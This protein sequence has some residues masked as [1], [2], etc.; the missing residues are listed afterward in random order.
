[1]IHGF[2]KV[3]AGHMNDINYS[4][5]VNVRPL[6]KIIFCIL[7]H[8]YLE[9]LFDEN[10]STEQSIFFFIMLFFMK[11]QCATVKSALNSKFP[12]SIISF[13]RLSMYLMIILF[14]DL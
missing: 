5:M 9:A 2:G 1:M 11:W 8:A 14:G 12:M 6:A 13:I 7:S 4:L 3:K 10:V